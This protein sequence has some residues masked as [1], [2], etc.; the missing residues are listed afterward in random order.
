MRTITADLP[1]MTTASSANPSYLLTNKSRTMPVPLLMTIA[2]IRGLQPWVSRPL[3]CA[4]LLANMQQ[5]IANRTRKTKITEGTGVCRTPM[6]R[7]DVSPRRRRVTRS[8]R[9]AAIGGAIL[10]APFSFVSS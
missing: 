8:P 4:F 5:K 9:H 10:S 2:P 6:K 1:L 3:T 7:L